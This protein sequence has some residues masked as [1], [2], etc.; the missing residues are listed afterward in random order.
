MTCEFRFQF[1]TVIRLIP[2]H[3]FLI[4]FRNS[5]FFIFIKLH[6]QLLVNNVNFLEKVYLGVWD[7]KLENVEILTCFDAV[8]RHL[9]C[10]IQKHKQCTENNFMQ[11]AL[12]YRDVFQP[13]SRVS[14]GNNKT[15][16]TAL[17]QNMHIVQLI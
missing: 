4:F 8:L 1:F 16:Y 13:C 11:Y 15:I 9:H 5:F 2:C 14:S 17:T 6:F 12:S 7:H 3:F 10:Y